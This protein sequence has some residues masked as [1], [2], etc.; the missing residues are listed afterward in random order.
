MSGEHR[1]TLDKPRAENWL[2]GNADTGT[3][4]PVIDDVW[5]PRAFEQ[6]GMVQMLVRNAVDAGILRAPEGSN[7]DFEYVADCDGG[8][9]YFLIRTEDN[10][11]KLASCSREM[12]HL[13]ESGLAGVPAAIAILDEAAWSA[14]STLADLDEVA[15]GRAARLAGLDNQERVLR[16]IAGFRGSM[17]DGYTSERVNRVLGAIS[18]ATGTDLVCVWEYCDTW[19]T[20][21]SSQFYVLAENGN[22]HE[23]TGDLWPWLSSS[24]DDPDAPDGPGL[25]DTWTGTLADF[26]VDDL[27]YDDGLRNYA[28]LDY[29]RPG[30]GGNGTPTVAE[31]NSPAAAGGLLLTREQIRSWAGLGRYLDA[32]ELERLGNCIPGSSVPDAVGTIVDGMG[33]RRAEEED[34]G[35]PAILACGRSPRRAVPLRAAGPKRPGGVPGRGATT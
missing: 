23:V 22:L 8:Y 2:R 24:P 31:T 9:Y 29:N 11:L 18:D 12:R 7:L 4:A 28:R 30:P 34:D 3:E 17:T 32:A 10:R 14:N 13:G 25:P 20:G 27:R 15:A 21:G 33:L 6:E 26:T 5:D 19:G 35:L 16:A 1:F